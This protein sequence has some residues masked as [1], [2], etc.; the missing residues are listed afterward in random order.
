M[1][2]TVSEGATA[3]RLPYLDGL[4]A[5]AVLAVVLCHAAKYTMDIRT[6][7][8]RVLYEGAHGV[9]LFFVISGVCLSYPVLRR[10]SER[11]RASFNVGGFFARRIIRIFPPYWIAFALVWASTAL[12]VH[13]GYQAPWPT[14]KMPNL[15]YALQQL[16][17]LARG[18]DLV[19]SFWTLSVE[20]RW[21]LAFPLLL[22]LWVR[23]PMLFAA[24][25]AA[26]VVV[27]H[28][29]GGTPLD[30]ATLPAFMF[31]IVAADWIVRRHPIAP[32]ALALVIPS[33]IATVAFEPGHLAFAYQD[34]LGWQV[35]SFF[36]VVG[37]CTTPWAKRLLSTTPMTL[38]GAASYSIYLYHDP[39]MG[40]Y[41]H[42]GGASVIAAVVA[43]TAGG[44]LAWM[45][46]ER[47]FLRSHARTRAIAWIEHRFAR[48]VRAATNGRIPVIHLA[49]PHPVM[50]ADP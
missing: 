7:S 43:G 44:I 36:L 34:Q 48:L 8:F 32:W 49:G 30:I 11:E 14:I 20:F 39:I 40:W 10:L 18:D 25:G 37:G 23:S 2:A 4:R 27:Y 28:A 13:A 42:Y 15:P 45:L 3:E 33:V 19:G 26:C 31:G 38:I 24:L 35:V 21:Y 12:L 50:V 5:V 29:V 17:L 1:A 6:L 47:P 46:F 41:G 16:V 9:D 22:W